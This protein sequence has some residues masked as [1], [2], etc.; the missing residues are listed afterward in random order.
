MP[1][2]VI[3]QLIMLIMIDIDRISLKTHSSIAYI[4]ILTIKLRY[5]MGKH[6]S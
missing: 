2:T 3:Q 1:L 5:Y 4:D 6:S